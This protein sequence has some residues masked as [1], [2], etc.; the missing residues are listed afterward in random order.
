MEI[1]Y[2]AG[3]FVAGALVWEFLGSTIKVWL[4]LQERAVGTDIKNAAGKAATDI[5]SKL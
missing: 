5:K 3:A 4:H 1:L 2:I